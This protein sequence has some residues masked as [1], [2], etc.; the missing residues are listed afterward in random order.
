MQ[1][2]CYP[3]HNICKL[4]NFE[5]FP[6]WYVPDSVLSALANRN[7][8]KTVATRLNEQCLR[9]TWASKCLSARCF[10]NPLNVCQCVFS[11]CGQIE[12]PIRNWRTWKQMDLFCPQEWKKKGK[13]ITKLFGNL[14]NMLYLHIQ[15]ICFYY[16]ELLSSIRLSSLP[17]YQAFRK[18]SLLSFLQKF[19][20]RT[21]PFL[22]IF[23]SSKLINC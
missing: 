4:L 9:I 12:T 20:F 1:Y 18:P 16:K 7:S 14:E 19:E 11:R 2:V 6:F 10:C 22:N 3:R 21:K 13:S 17:S 15:C 8:T 5:C 23:I